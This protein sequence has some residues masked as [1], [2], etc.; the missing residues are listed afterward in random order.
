MRGRHGQ[1]LEIMA[2]NLDFSLDEFGP[3]ALDA[4]KDL[5][6]NSMCTVFAESEVHRSLPKV[7][8][9]RKLLGASILSVGQACCGHAE[10][11]G[12]P[13]SYR[14]FRRGGTKSMYGANGLRRP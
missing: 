1:I 9:A 10:P 6:I 12:G 8:T 11:R 14:I 3:A 4:Q 7:W 2:H 13:G 5:Q